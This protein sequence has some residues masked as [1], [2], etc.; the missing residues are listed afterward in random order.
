MKFEGVR[1]NST[2]GMEVSSSNTLKI[3]EDGLGVLYIWRAI[4]LTALGHPQEKQK[5]VSGQSR[6]SPWGVWPGE[7][8]LLSSTWKQICDKRDRFMGTCNQCYGVSGLSGQGKS[9]KSLD[10][11]LVE[12]WG[13][14]HLAF[15]VLCK[16][17]C[18]NH[19]LLKPEAWP[20]HVTLY[21]LSTL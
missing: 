12:N 15:C 13:P 6:V 19:R 10:V 1:Q 8:L 4:R 7:V 14:T 18:V 3:P 9:G 11:L 17:D 5:P 2:S 20:F 21:C 16:A